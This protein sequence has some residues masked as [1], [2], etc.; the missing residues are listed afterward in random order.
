MPAKWRFEAVQIIV[1]L[2][3]FIASAAVWTRVPERMPVHWNLAGEPDRYG[4]KVEGLLLAPLIAVGLYLMF[5]VLPLIDPRRSSYVNFAR[6]YAIIR[7]ATI[8]LVAAIHAMLLLVALGYHV[9]VGMFVSLAV[10]GLFCII[11]NFM[12]KF[13]PNW[14]VGI[15]TPW[16]LSSRDAWNKTNRLGGRFFIALGFVLFLMAFMPNAWTLALLLGMVALMVV[17][18]PVY[19]YLVWRHDPDRGRAGDSST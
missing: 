12:G 13:R 18:L 6:G 14:F 11:G 16:T 5:L 4:G 7:V 15:R 1:I 17:W 8:V 10:G 9:N 3:M 2:G 19:S